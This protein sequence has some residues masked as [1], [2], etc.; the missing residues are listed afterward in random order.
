MAKPTDIRAA[1]TELFFLPVETRVPLKFGPGTLT[2]VTCARARL[3]V[4]LGNGSTATGWGETPLSVQWVWPSALPYEPRHQALKEFCVRLAKAWAAF[5]ASGHSLELGHDFQQTELPKLLEAFNADSP[6]GEPMPWLAAL[7]CC[8]LFDIALHDALGQALG[9]P[10]YE[11]YTP[12]FLSR[13]LGQFLEPANGSDVNFAGRFPNEFLA[14]DP[15]QTMPAWHLVGGLDPLDESELIGDEPDDGY[16]VLLADWIR[17]DGLTCLKVKL[18]GNDAGWDY[19]RLAKVG[20]IGIGH[21]VLWLTA[22]FNCTVTEPAY[23]NEILDR[24][25]EEQPQLYGMILYVEQP[26]PYELE[27]HRIDVHSVSARKPL[28]W[29]LIRLGR[30]LGWTGVALKTCKTQTGAIL[31]ACWAKAHGMTLMVQDL[32]NPMLAQIPHVQLAARVGTIM[33]VETNSMQFYP[34]ASAAEAMVH[35]GIYRRRDGRIDLSTL[36]GPGFGYRLEEIDRDLPEPAAAF[37]EG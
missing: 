14:A 13:D 29:K 27:T 28:D 12:E 35:G 37:G 4:R 34:E 5:D 3:T 21:G 30:E 19:E 36:T 24:L 10:T 7:V 17:I 6:A 25:A 18:R 23:V 33:G 9:R 20:A 11:T 1:A 16:P 31:S 22:D 26:F 8:S 15:L 32:T 2:H